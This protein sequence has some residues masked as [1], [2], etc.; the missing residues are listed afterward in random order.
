MKAYGGMDVK[1]HIFL[2]SA[3]VG[4]EWSPSRLGR[5][6]PGTNWIGDDV[7]KRKFIILLAV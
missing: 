4:G 7:E 3:L 6:T 1:T 5:F 2:F